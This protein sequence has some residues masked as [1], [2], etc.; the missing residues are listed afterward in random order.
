[1]LRRTALAAAVLV[2]ALA[3]VLVSLG[4][5][6]A[7]TKRDQVAS[8]GVTTPQQARATMVDHGG[9]VL[10]TAHL[11]LIWWG[12][13]AA[14][15]A[16]ERATVQHLLTSLEGTAY[17]ATVNPY[18]R[19][20]S[21]HVTYDPAT[22]WAD[23]STPPAA[24][25]A[26]DVAAEVSRYLAATHAAAD[27]KAVYLVYSTARVNGDQCAWHDTRAVRSGS[28][29]ALVNVAYVPDATG[30]ARCDLGVPAT[31]A[32]AAALSAASSTAHEL[33]ETMADPIP[34][35]TWTDSASSVDEIAD[36]CSS[37][38]REVRLAGGPALPLQSIW[39]NSAH[40]CV[41]S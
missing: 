9:S 37:Q 26:D 17:L 34:G 24:A 25:T 23:A 27:P 4:T 5:A 1:M 32:S 20:A 21:A 39:S 10:A 13:G 12:Q 8:N 31:A 30:A 40:S 36:P 19:G 18:L 35:A 15:P 2:G 3:L 22:D 6:Q 16:D 38:I 29:A 14:F 33:I 28:A 7:L 41:V 11:H